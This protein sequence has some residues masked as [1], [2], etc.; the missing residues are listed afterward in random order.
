V[1]AACSPAWREYVSANG[2]FRVL[3]PGDLTEERRTIDTP[4]G[5]RES[6]SVSAVLNR[7]PWLA[8]RGFYFVTYADLGDQAAGTS[9][10]R[11]LDDEREEAVKRLNGRVVR[12]QAVSLGHHAGLEIEVATQMGL[13]KERI[14]LV[15]QRVYQ[16]VVGGKMEAS[17]PGADKFFSSFRLLES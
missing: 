6:V 8:N 11:L 10:E 4:T 14:Y 12:E 7:K 9:P 3:M 5:K 13:V 2:R 1:A 15:N 17:S 16:L